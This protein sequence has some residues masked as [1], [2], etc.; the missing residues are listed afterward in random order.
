MKVFLDLYYFNINRLRYISR[1][2]HYYDYR[3]FLVFALSILKDVCLRMD[4]KFHVKNVCSKI[5]LLI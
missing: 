3:S 5:A 2:L 4:L 1:H